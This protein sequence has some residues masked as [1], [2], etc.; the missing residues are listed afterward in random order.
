[1]YGIVDITFVGLMHKLEQLVDDCLQEF[2][3][4][5]EEAGVLPD[6]VHDIGRHDRL[7]IFP[8]FHLT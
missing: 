3:V 1:M 8:A 6:N 2:P 7:I 5:F 4:C